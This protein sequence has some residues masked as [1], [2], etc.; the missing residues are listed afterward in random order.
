MID[1]N[2]N[3]S[4]TNEALKVEADSL[5]RCLKAIEMACASL[6]PGQRDPMNWLVMMARDHATH[7][8]IAAIS[9][10]TDKKDEGSNSDSDSAS[11]GD[12]K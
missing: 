1:Q 11:K 3:L 8:R 9:L 5:E 6:P 12:A 2:R 7:L 4:S 10:L